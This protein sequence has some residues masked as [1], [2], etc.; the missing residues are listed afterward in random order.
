V[1]S[2]DSD[3]LVKMQSYLGYTSNLTSATKL[4]V[5]EITTFNF[6]DT[7]VV[8]RLKNFGLTQR[9]SCNETVPDCFKFN[10]H[11]WRGLIDADGCLYLKVNGITK[12]NAQL[13]L[14]SSESC[15]RDFKFFCESVINCNVRISSHSISTGVKYATL[16]GDS[17]RKIIMYL[18][19]NCSVFLDR[20]CNTATMAYYDFWKLKCRVSRQKP[21]KESDNTWTMQI[22]A[23]GKTIRER[24]FLTEED[25]VNAR[26]SFVDHLNLKTK[27]GNEEWLMWQHQKV[28][29]Q[30]DMN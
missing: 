20:K 16:T 5:G 21:V 11:F 28:F 30:S 7:D 10:R 22:Y 2:I 23:N 12:T 6:S 29:R 4:N 14:V 19:N 26:N 8:K 18:Y 24:G 1:K 15:A 25:A 9:K 13:S 17:A 3:V 27:E